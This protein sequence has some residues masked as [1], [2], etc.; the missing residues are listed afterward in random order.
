MLCDFFI[1]CNV[2]SQFVHNTVFFLGQMV[3]F[4]MLMVRY[5]FIYRYETV[6]QNYCV[7][8]NTK[9]STEQDYSLNMVNSS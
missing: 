1:F 9:L 7:Y 6:Y 2:I 8:H 5:V 4:A 3:F